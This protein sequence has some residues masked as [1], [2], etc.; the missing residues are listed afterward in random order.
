MIQKFLTYMKECGWNVKMKEKQ[1]CDL[2]ETVKSRYE[3]IPEIWFE[4]I[5]TVQSIVSSDETT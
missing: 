5:T 3:H 1:S 2:P 4:F